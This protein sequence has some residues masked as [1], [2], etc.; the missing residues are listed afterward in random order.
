[1]YGSR[2]ER[3]E[4][5]CF[6]VI[7]M[8]TLL[9]ITPALAQETMDKSAIETEAER[10]KVYMKIGTVTVTEE[11]G[12]L[13]TADMPGSVD[14]IGAEQ[15]ERENIDFSMQL[16]KKLPGV[17]YEDWNQGVIHGNIGIRGF[18]PNVETSVALYVDGIPN[19][20][21]SGYMDMRAFFPFELERIELVKGTND[22]RYGLNNIAGNVNV[23][24]KRGGNY[25]KA[26][27]LYGS[28]DTIDGNAI[29]ACEK[30][31]F[32]Q[33]YF[34]GYRRTDGYRTHS[35]VEKGAVSG[36]WFYTT[37]DD[38]L[39]VGAIARYFD[40]DADS[41]GYLNKEQF[42]NDP[43]QNQGFSGTD[44]GEQKNQQGSLHLD[45][46]FTDNLSWSFKAYTQHLERSRWV[47]FSAAGA[48]HERFTD[49]D[50][51]GAISTLTYETTDWGIEN[52]ELTWGIDYQYQDSEYQRCRTV[53]RIRQPGGIF[54]D[55]DYSQWFLGSYVQAD[56]KITKWLRLI[57]ALRV[58]NFDGDYHDKIADT[59]SDMIDYG[60]IWQPKVGAVITPY[61]GYNLYGNWGRA[62]QIGAWNARFSDQDMDYSKNDGWEAGVKLS[63]FNCLAARLSYWEQDASNE[64]RVNIQG[65]PENLGETDRDG[66]DLGLSIKPHKWVTLW[67]AY[68]KVNAVYTEPGP[69]L[70]A[71]KGKDI[72]NIPDY[73]AKVGIDFE[74]PSSFWSSVW[75]E[76]QG[77][78]PVDAENTLP[79]EGDYNVVNLDLGYK[80]KKAILGFQI[81]NLFDEKYNGFVWRQTWGTPETWFSPGDERS[82]YGSLTFEF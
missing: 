7:L 57:G 53:D 51:S 23:Y 41:P 69:T 73:T 79:R 34:L 47:R 22:P 72:K 76:S 37:S 71:R 65:D 49:E 43:Q 28:F 46:Y 10:D 8:T 32:S 61:P 1:M 19:N 6:L 59:E 13:T 78:Y 82:F 42:E 2:N 17:Y 39:T 36:K 38:R 81:R 4:H 77:D 64:V 48:Q 16:L 40:M 31:G 18:D 80:I 35:D 56:N 33:T 9:M 55:W 14:V 52:I 54:R 45:Y 58:D 24:T 63:P 12:Y 20:L 3:K 60:K 25:A 70:L 75:L 27:L 11:A 67:G 21:S 74:H 68:S 5:I 62:F 66:W 50:Q 44:G 26:K 15:L 29:V 30:D